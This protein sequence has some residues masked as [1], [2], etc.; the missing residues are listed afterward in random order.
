MY[1]FS[2]CYGVPKDSDLRK[3]GVYCIES[4]VSGKQ[5]IGST[6]LCFRDRSQCHNRQLR[7][8]KHHSPIF[9]RS[10]T[11]N[12]EDSFKLTILEFLEDKDAELLQQRE[13]YWLD[14]LQPVFNIYK[15]ACCFEPHKHSPEHKEVWVKNV[16]NRIS[17]QKTGVRKFLK[18]DFWCVFMRI[19]GFR[20]TSMGR[21]KTK[22][23]ALVVRKEM[24]DLFWNPE[25]DALTIQEKRDAIKVYREKFPSIRD[26]TSKTPEVG[27]GYCK[28]RK[29]PYLVY[30]QTSRGTRSASYF[31]TLE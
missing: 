25:F 3:F 16:R 26:I 10:Y 4:S 12:G 29:K 19:N 8:G 11:K 2:D 31:S 15:K 9:Q 21:F 6:L 23:E 14:L 22:E 17:K 5:Y 28:T 18:T 24:E 27:T 13:Q 1:S 20:I 7:T 30:Y